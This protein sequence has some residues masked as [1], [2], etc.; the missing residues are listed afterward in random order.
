MAC[1]ALV[2]GDDDLGRGLQGVEDGGPGGELNL[3]VPDPVTS[4]VYGDEGLDLALAAPLPAEEHL[5]GGL[6]LRYKTLPAERLEGSVL[7]YMLDLV[8]S[9]AWSDFHVAEEL[10][11]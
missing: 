4:I 10:G 7:L 1:G 3:L 9:E 2:R 5:R 6:A 11:G 8:A